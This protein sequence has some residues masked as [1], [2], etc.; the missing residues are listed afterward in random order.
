MRRR[1]RRELLRER[2]VR[3]R[4]NEESGR[5]EVVPALV[6]VPPGERAAHAEARRER[7]AWGT[8]GRGSSRVELGLDFDFV[9]VRSWGARDTPAWVQVLT[10]CEQ[11]VWA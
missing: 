6:P 11:G 1:V 5:R 2:K 3:R 4:I 7:A 10:V 8:A 9:Y